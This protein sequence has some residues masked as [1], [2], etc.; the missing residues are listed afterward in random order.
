MT[1]RRRV[2]FLLQHALT[3]ELW[4]TDPVAKTQH[5]AVLRGVRTYTRAFLQQYAVH[6]E[7]LLVELLYHFCN[8]YAYLNRSLAG[9]KNETETEIGLFVHSLSW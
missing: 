5:P 1:I 3:V 2:A 9:V 8:P 4:Q 6:S 7:T